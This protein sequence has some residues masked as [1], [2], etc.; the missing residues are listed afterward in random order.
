MLHL[1]CNQTIAIVLM[2][3]IIRTFGETKI[4]HKHAFATPKLS[5]QPIVTNIFSSFSMGALELA[6]PYG[7]SFLFM[8]I[9]SKSSLVSSKGSDLTVEL[10]YF[11]T[12]LLICQD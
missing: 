11:S 8:G 7:F 1:T 6:N 2:I 3:I 10:P 12:Y 4:N 9:L 5:T